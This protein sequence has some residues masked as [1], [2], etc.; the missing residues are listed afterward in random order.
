MILLL[1]GCS[2]DKTFKRVEDKSVVG[3]LHSFTILASNKKLLK[4]AKEASKEANINITPSP[5]SIVVESSKYPQHCNN[6]LTPAYEASYD[7]YVKLTVKKGFKKIYFIQRDFHDDVTQ[8]ILEDL[9][10]ILKKDLKVT[11]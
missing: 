3:K 6:P 1:L 9:L 7:G 8:G 4:M 11:H 10:E 2:E 5:Y